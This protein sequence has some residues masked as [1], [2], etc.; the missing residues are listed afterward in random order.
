MWM[1]NPRPLTVETPGARGDYFEVDG[2]KGVK[3]SG[4][5]M[6][7]NCLAAGVTYEQDARFS[8]VSMSH[9]LTIVGSA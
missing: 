4:T 3:R 7:L 2:S 9:E 5:R 6:P 8:L 1:F